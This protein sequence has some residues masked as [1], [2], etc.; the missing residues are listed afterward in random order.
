M[1]YSHVKAYGDVLPKWVTFLPKFLDMGP[2]LVKKILR[3]G[4]H[5]TKIEKSK[6]SCFWGRKILTN[7]SW[8]A[9][10]SRKKSYQLVFFFFFFEGEKSLDMD[11][12]FRPQAA[13]PHQKKKKKMSTPPPRAKQFQ[14]KCY[15][16]SCVT[17]LLIYHRG[18][19]KFIQKYPV[20]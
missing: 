15:T 14:L 20:S 2:I 16:P 19:K 12:G 8:C 13:H 10:I 9:K 17:P 3:R 5:F 11:R 4:F 7:G 6:I 18:C 1:G